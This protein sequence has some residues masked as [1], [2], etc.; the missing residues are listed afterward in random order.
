MGGLSRFF[1]NSFGSLFSRSTGQ[2]RVTSYVLREHA[3]GRDLAEI[4]EDPYL[5]NR[6]TPN[7]RARLLDRPEIIRALG[8]DVAQAAKTELPS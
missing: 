3:R 7:E 4:L 5:K 1:R 8:E 2:D 6:L